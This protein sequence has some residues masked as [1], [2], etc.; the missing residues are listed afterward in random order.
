MGMDYIC[1]INCEPLKFVRFVSI[2]FIT[3]G[4]LN[5]PDCIITSTNLAKIAFV[6]GKNIREIT[7]DEIR[8]SGLD[9]IYYE[10]AKVSS[11]Q[12]PV[13]PETTE[14]TFTFTFESR[15]ET[16]RLRYKTSV[17]IISDSCGAFTN[18]GDLEIIDTTFTETE[19][20]AN[21]LSTNATVNIQ[22]SVD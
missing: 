16:L 3:V 15:V 5:E 17:Q 6:N 13:N 14:I 1:T 4:C 2:F 11:V 18:Y 7:F 19:I 21:Q 9:K 12:L 8:V 10:D 22:I 20:V